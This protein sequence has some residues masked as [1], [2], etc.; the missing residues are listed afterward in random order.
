LLL[1]AFLSYYAVFAGVRILQLKQLHRAQIPKWYDWAGGA[2]NGI[3]NLVFIVFGLHLLMVDGWTGG[4]LLSLGFGMGGLLLTY[5][6]VKPFILRP[7][8]ANHW[9]VSHMGNM[10]GAYI[11]TLT[12]FLSTLVSKYQLMNPFLAF[13]LPSLIGIPLL[14]YWTRREERRYDSVNG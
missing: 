8:R 11:A 7:K 1:I 10:M 2:L 14:I 6:N 9:Y 3:A 12:A 4:S 13:A 5:T